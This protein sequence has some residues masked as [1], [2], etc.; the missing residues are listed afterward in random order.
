MKRYT[1]TNPV[2][3][4]GITY[5][6]IGIDNLIL[7]ITVPSLT[8]TASV[9]PTAVEQIPSYTR[10]LTITGAQYTALGFSEGALVNQ[11]KTILQVS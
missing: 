11:L 7:D 1:L 6:Q 9:F 3:I 8:L 5:Q 2:T 10:T 4:L